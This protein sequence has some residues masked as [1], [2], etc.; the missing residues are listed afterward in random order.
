M[1]PDPQSPLFTPV[2]SLLHHSFNRLFERRDIEV[3]GDLYLVRY[4]LDGRGT[5]QQR[6]VHHIIRPDAGRELHDHPWDFTTRILMGGYVEDARDYAAGSRTPHLFVRK[7]GDVISHAAEYAHRIE[8]VRPSTWTLVTA[9]AARR[10]WGFWS[11]HHGS[12]P[13]RTD[14]RT[15]LGTP[16][17]L[18]WP[19]DVIRSS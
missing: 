2:D 8:K 15:Y 4:Y 13:Y 14:W 6:F 11:D 9:G 1:G 10:V 5:D 17:A 3:D 7:G 18:D 12:P 19:E 16:D